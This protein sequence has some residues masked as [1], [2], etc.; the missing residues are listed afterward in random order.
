MHVEVF[1]M[2]GVGTF[3]LGRS[4]PVSPHRR[5]GTANEAITPSSAKSPFPLRVT[6]IGV[7]N[8]RRLCR[9]TCR[10]LATCWMTCGNAVRRSNFPGV[11]P[12]TTLLPNSGTR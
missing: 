9:E 6:G 1:R 5:A 4:R 3:I 12:C 7:S 2:G 10:C 8:L 11:F